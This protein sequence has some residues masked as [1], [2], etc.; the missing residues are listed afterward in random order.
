MIRRAAAVALFVA[1]VMPVSVL[2]AAGADRTLARMP[3]APEPPS[4]RRAVRHIPHVPAADRSRPGAVGSV[5]APPQGPDAVPHAGQAVRPRRVRG[6]QP[7]QPGDDAG[8]T[9]RVRSR[10]AEANV[11]GSVSVAGP[12]AVYELDRV[13]LPDSLF[14]ARPPVAEAPAPA[15]S[16]GE[17]AASTPP[18]MEPH[19]HV[20]P[21]QYG[22]AG[23]ADT[24]TSSACRPWDSRNAAAAA[25]GAL[26]ILVVV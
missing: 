6:A 21:R 15:P 7:E 2:H 19:H 17:E 26:L 18:V 20:A 13:L 14:P 12:M 9:V 25:F 8:G 22:S 1:A 3:L 4:K 11:V 24:P 5:E 16:L 23:T 10:W